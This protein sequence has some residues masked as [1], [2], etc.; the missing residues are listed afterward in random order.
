MEGMK[1][2]SSE[3]D[4]IASPAHVKGRKWEDILKALLEGQGYTVFHNYELPDL[5]VVKNGRG[6]WIECKNKE[7]MKYHPAT[8][9]PTHQHPKYKLCQDLTS[10]PVFVAFN[11][12]GVH[13]GSWLND[14]NLNIYRERMNTPQGDVILF[15]METMFPLD[16]GMSWNNILSPKLRKAEVF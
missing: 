13:Y 11:D 14:L 7:R 4:F 15:K 16:D 12:K 10:M 2:T 3:A 6:L 5:F 9:Y 1:L 8:G